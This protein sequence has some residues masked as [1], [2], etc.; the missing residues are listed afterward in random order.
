[1]VFLAG[2]NFLS[3]LKEFFKLFFWRIDYFQLLMNKLMF[4][5]LFIINHLAIAQMDNQAMGGRALGAGNAVVTVA[6]SWSLFNNVGALGNWEQPAMMLAYDYRYGFASFQTI[7]VGA[8]APLKKGVVGLNFTR[9]GDELYNE[10]KIGLGYSYAIENVSLGLKINYLQVYLQDLASRGN[11]VFEL[12]GVAK[13]SKSLSFGAYIYNFSQSKINSQFDESIR[14]PIVMKA[15]LAY[16]PIK[17]LQLNIET[18]KNLD[19]PNRI[20]FGLDYQ[21]VKKVYLRSGIQTQ[22][23]VNHYGVG[24]KPRRWQ[25]DYA[26]HTHSRLG[27]AHHISF[28][29]WLGK[30]NAKAEQN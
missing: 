20:K 30:I 15:G 12:G 14:I 17:V 5:I 19:F 4:F 29:Y 25:F 28:S 21:L 11:L 27:W 1:M 10:Q 9:F 7:A 13:L 16:Q 3:N 23:W 22:P 18:E 8:V 2:L 6:D 24:F 26:L